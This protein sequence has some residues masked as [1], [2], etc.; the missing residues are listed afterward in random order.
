M[1]IH[2][3]KTTLKVV[4]VSEVEDPVSV[5]PEHFLEP[6]WH[7]GVVLLG[8]MD[9]DLQQ[10]EEF[11]HRLCDHF[12]RSAA[13][14]DL[15]QSD[16]DGYSVRTPKGNFTL[17]AHNEGSY[18]PFQPAH[19]AFFLCIEGPS[20]RGGETLL[21]DGRSFYQALPGQLARTLKNEGV[22]YSA[23][24][25]TERWQA[26]LGVED[27]QELENLAMEN[28]DFS[29]SF[30]SDEMHYQCKRNAIVEDLQGEPVFANAFLA[31]L[32]EVTLPR[33]AQAN[34]YAS[35]TNK[36]CFGSGDVP[37]EADIQ[38]LIDIQDKV[39]YEHAP[40]A[41]D[42]LVIDN[43]RVMHGRRSTEGDCR[44]ELLTR[45]GYLREEFKP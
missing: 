32:P 6:L 24:W 28:H 40:A 12:H 21:V 29:F 37:S 35:K 39:S 34:P 16:G 14:D 7:S 43:S 20:S 30:E 22:V 4:D 23:R 41:G 5:P 42:L 31:H 36:V 1:S 25:D 26:E 15:R 13:R 17:L 27:I 9:L 44:R 11:T 19:L 18:R 10:F 45:F 2:G 33:Y 8:G 3:A 38:T